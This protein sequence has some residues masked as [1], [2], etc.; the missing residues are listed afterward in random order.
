MISNTIGDLSLTTTKA[1]LLF[2]P[3][4]KSLVSTPDPLDENT[5]NVNHY[6]CDK[7]K[8]TAGT[9]K[10][11]KGLVAHVTEQFI[12]NTPKQFDLR[13]PK[14]L[15]MP[16]DENDGGEKNPSALLVCYRAKPSKGQ[17]KTT[18]TNTFV[19]NEFGSGTM[20]TIKES[21]LCGRP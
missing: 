1:D 18:R 11:P 6:K 16:V 15:C 9:P 2:V 5:I 4:A 12:G 21:E 8:V 7:V 17:P 10:F 13:K 3:T 19:N 20:S 14:H